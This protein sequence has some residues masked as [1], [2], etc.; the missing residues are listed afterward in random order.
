MNEPHKFVLNLS[1]ILDLRSSNQQFTLQNLSIY[2]TLK[3]IRK[4]YNDNKL[5]IIAPTLNDECEL[6]GGSYSVS[7]NQDYI[8]YIIRKHKTWTKIPSIHVYISRI[9]S[10]LVFKIKHGLG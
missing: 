10:R 4:Q 5:K 3:N 8:E 1:Q 7:D 2:Y 9:N 6:R